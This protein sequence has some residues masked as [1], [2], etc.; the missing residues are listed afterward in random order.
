MLLLEAGG[1]D[2]DP[3]IQ[4]PARLGPHPARPLHDWMYFAEPE[5]DA[6]RPRDRMRARQGDRRLVL[7]QRHG[8]CARPPRRLRPLG[9][10]RPARLV[11]RA[12]AALFPPRRRRWEGGAERLSRR[13][14]AADDAARALSPTRW[15]RPIVEAGRDGRPS[16][17]PTTTTAR[18][19]EG[20]GRMQM[21]IRDG[22]RCSAAVAYLRPALARA[23]SRRSRPT[24]WR[25]ASCS[26]AAA[27]SASNIAQGGETHDRRAPSAR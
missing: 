9:R 22:R 12:R 20:F 25:P 8:L 19:Q 21:T 2:R 14:R 4:H 6:G 26:R 27:P 1:W 23:Q 18:E 3:W 17:R 24:R 13:R 15:S 5:A 10:S 16:V 11:L 7:D